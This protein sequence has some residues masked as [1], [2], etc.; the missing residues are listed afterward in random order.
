MSEFRNRYKHPCVY[1]LRTSRALLEEL[2]VMAKS[3]Q[4]FK[5]DIVEDAIALYRDTYFGG[6]DFEKTQ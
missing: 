2:E 6:V 4:R 1:A 5:C 3:E